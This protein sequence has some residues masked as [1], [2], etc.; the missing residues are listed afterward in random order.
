MMI[1]ITCAWLG[2]K[3]KLGEVAFIINARSVCV[4]K[5]KFKKKT[6]TI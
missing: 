6:K 3:Q 2:Q 4:V 1:M 5:K